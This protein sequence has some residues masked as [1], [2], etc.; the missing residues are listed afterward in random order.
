MRRLRHTLIDREVIKSYSIEEVLLRLRQVWGE[1]GA[2][3]WLFPF[4][5]PQDPIRFDELPPDQSIRCPTEALDKL[6]RVQKDLWRILHEQRRRHDRA[7]GND[8]NFRREDEIALSYP[9]RIYDRDISICGDDMLVS[10]A[11]EYAGMLAAL[12]WATDDRWEWQGPGIM[13]LTLNDP[14]HPKGQ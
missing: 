9:L 11:C 6:D 10:A 7:A 8:P 5:D 4:V 1:F 14:E 3:C 13:D 2:L 12:R